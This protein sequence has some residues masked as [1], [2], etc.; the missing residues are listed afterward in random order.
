MNTLQINFVEKKER[1][2]TLSFINYFIQD[3]TCR[4]IYRVQQHAINSR[5]KSALVREEGERER[6]FWLY[7]KTKTTWKYCVVLH[8]CDKLW[9]MS[10]LRSKM[11]NVEAIFMFLLLEMMHLLSRAMQSRAD[12]SRVEPLRCLS[13]QK[14][15]KVD[16]YVIHILKRLLQIFCVYV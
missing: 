2:G 13:I 15:F 14:S 6:R 12:I 4:E 9:E 11:S 3:C 5:E 8:S 7:K 16:T 10:V 1:E